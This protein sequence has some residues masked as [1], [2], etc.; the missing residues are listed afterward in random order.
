MEL[1]ETLHRIDTAEFELQCFSWAQADRDGNT[2]GIS[3]R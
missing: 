1:E 2:T 3:L